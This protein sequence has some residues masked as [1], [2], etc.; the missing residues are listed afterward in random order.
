MAR[1]PP[2]PIVQYPTPANVSC[3]SDNNDLARPRPHGLPSPAPENVIYAEADI[4][5]RCAYQLLRSKAQ[6]THAVES[7]SVREHV[8][9]REGDDIINDR[10]HLGPALDHSSIRERDASV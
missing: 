8:V 6:R 7:A 4:L 3:A 10:G 9:P 2:L 1:Y 5:Q